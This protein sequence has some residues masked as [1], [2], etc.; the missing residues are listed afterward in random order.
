MMMR[1]MPH[2]FESDLLAEWAGFT[3]FTSPSFWELRSSRHI[4]RF[5]ISHHLMRRAIKRAGLANPE[6]RYI[7]FR[8]LPSQLRPAF[9]KKNVLGLLIGLS[10]FDKHEYFDEEHL[11]RMIEKWSSSFRFVQGSRFLFRNPQDE[12]LCILYIEIDKEK[13]ELFTADERK[14]SQTN[15]FSRIKRPRSKACSPSFYRP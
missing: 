15:P 7:S 12:K 10:L 6:K 4:S 9:G 8:F 3:A 5:M 11:V 14:I 13:G 2:L 1:R